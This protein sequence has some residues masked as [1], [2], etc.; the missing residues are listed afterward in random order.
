MPDNVVFDEVVGNVVGNG[1]PAIT[2]A[3]EEGQQGYAAK[4]VG[5]ER[6]RYDLARLAR[7]EAR[8]RAD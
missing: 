7:R 4:E 3:A 5:A 8:L 6:L 2:P 1:E